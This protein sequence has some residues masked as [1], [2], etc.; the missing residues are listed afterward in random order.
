[1]VASDAPEGLA[2]LL[3]GVSTP[4]RDLMLAGRSLI[5]DV[6]PDV[7]EVVWPNQRIVGFGVGPKKMSEQYVYLAAYGRHVNLGFYYGADLDD[8]EEMLRGT[9]NAMRHIRIEDVDDLEHPAVRSLIEQ[10]KG[11]L[12]RLEG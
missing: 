3:E 6:A 12:P 9:G 8:P 7:V 10:A 11:Y 4:V 5:R 1:M 2:E